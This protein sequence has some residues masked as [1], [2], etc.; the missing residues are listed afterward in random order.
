MAPFNW[1]FNLS[2]KLFF[3]QKSKPRIPLIQRHIRLNQ[4]QIKI[5]SPEETININ[6]EN[7]V[8]FHCY[9]GGYCGY[10]KPFNKYSENGK[11]NYLF[12]RTNDQ[13]KRLLN[14]YISNRKEYKFIKFL[15][16]NAKYN[17]QIKEMPIHDAESYTL[18]SS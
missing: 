18:I 13:K 15:S 2:D 9:Y 4:Y 8:E 10:H 7:I 12:L 5:N 14:I 3:Y 17:L 16:E 6:S 1:S 11:N